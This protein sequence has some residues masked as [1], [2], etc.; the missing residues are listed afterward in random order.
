MRKVIYLENSTYLEKD[1]VYL[2][3][4]KVYTVLKYL[5]DDKDD[6]ILIR[7]DND[8]SGVYYITGAFGEK[9]FEDYTQKFRNDVIDGILEV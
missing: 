7:D 1:M 3:P 5:C 9:C 4:G 8:E 2:T 6:R